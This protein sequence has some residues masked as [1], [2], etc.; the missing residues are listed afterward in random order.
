VLALD[1]RRIHRPSGGSL[2]LLHNAAQALQLD[3]ELR[4]DSAPDAPELQLGISRCATHGR[5]SKPTLVAPDTFPSP[6]LAVELLGI[7]GLGSSR[8][9][10]LQGVP[11][12]SM[13]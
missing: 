5:R 4:G 7:H 11:G 3:P 13:L 1:R 12:G 6:V 10:T 9:Q 8:M 2:D